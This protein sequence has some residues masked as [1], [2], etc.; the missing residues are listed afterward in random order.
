MKYT[1]SDNYILGAALFSLEASRKST[2]RRF[3]RTFSRSAVVKSSF[4]SFVAQ[5]RLS[6][7]CFGRFRRLLVL[8]GRYRVQTVFFLR[9][10]VLHQEKLIEVA[11][12]GSCRFGNPNIAAALLFVSF[13]ISQFFLV[14]HFIFV[15]RNFSRFMASWKSLGALSMVPYCVCGP[16]NRII[17]RSWRP[18]SIMFIK[19]VING[20]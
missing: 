19:A 12:E 9:C 14:L 5:G 16:S 3:N 4:R 20:F 1:G 8:Q 7:R 10:L 2:V 15:I 11:R 6:R 13:L 18:L 17:L